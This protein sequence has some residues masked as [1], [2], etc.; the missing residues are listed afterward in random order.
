MAG[1]WRDVMP[2]SRKLLEPITIDDGRTFTTL[3]EAAEFMLRLP[4]LLQASPRWIFAAEAMMKAAKPASS[5]TELSTAERRLRSAL[6][7]DGVLGLKR[8]TQ[9][10][11]RKPKGRQRR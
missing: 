9:S 11:R 8:E 7:A 6:R 1:I 10:D 4:D 2:W 5:K 3:R